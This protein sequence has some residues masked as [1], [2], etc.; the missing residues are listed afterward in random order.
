MKKYYAN[1]NYLHFTAMI[2]N[3]QKQTGGAPPKDLTENEKLV[4][5]L[6]GENSMKGMEYNIDTFDLEMEESST[7][8]ASKLNESVA[9]S[10]SDNIIIITHQASTFVF[11]NSVNAK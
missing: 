11:T 7:T 3:Y 4:V 1:V 5:L 9:S 10:S 8:S 6:A 2:N